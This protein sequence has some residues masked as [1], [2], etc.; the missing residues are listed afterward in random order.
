MLPHVPAAHHDVRFS[1]VIDVTN[2]PREPTFLTI[3][4]FHNK[5]HFNTISHTS[6]GQHHAIQRM[7]DMVLACAV[8]KKITDYEVCHIAKGPFR[9]AD[10]S[11]VCT[12]NVKLKNVHTTAATITRHRPTVTSPHGVESLLTLAT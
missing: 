7:V 4:H 12:R 8:N 3:V 2:Q 9:R 5:Q 1:V 11:D 6:K 10:F